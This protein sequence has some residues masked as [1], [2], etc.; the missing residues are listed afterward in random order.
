MIDNYIILLDNIPCCVYRYKDV[1]LT[2]F[3]L[4]NSLIPSDNPL[5]VNEQ[6]EINKKSYIIKDVALDKPGYIR[7]ECVEDK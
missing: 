1:V 7:L 6:L 5:Y 2:R 3:I 4:H